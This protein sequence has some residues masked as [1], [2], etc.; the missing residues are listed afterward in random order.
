ML[1]VFGLYE[2]ILDLITR[3]YSEVTTRRIIII[4][5]ILLTV[6]ITTFVL[7]GSYESNESKS[8]VVKSTNDYCLCFKHTRS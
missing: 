2:S 5:L 3:S 1:K 8:R 6:L 4:I 7:R